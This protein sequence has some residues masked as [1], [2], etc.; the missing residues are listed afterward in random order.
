MLLGFVLTTAGAQEAQ[1]DAYAVFEGR[2]VSDIELSAGPGTNSDVFR[3]RIKQQQGAP[4]SADAVRQSIAALQQTKWFSKVDLKVEPQP[5][6]LRI[7]FILQPASY[8]GIITFPG[9]G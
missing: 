2:T 7:T 9:A 5:S 4:F 6:G 1:P 8:V 3:P